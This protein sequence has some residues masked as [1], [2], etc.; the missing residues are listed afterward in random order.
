M[1]KAGAFFAGILVVAAVAGGTGS[2][3]AA[4]SAA[5]VPL[6]VKVAPFS[7]TRVDVAK[8]L[9]VIVSCS[10]DC[11]AKA[12]ITLITP[13]GNSS[14]AGGRT[15]TAQSSWVTGMILTRYGLSV[16][17]NH[18][19]RSRLKVAVTARDPRNGSIHRKTRFFRFRR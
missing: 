5:F 4:E 1:K 19:P 15:I 12:R 6:R 17:R 14:V 3:V 16:L 2:A 10:Q 13:A 8:S 18:Y 7:G 9:K 11:Q